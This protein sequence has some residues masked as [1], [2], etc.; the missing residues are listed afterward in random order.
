MGSTR[1]V[2]VLGAGTMGHG[3]AEVLAIHGIQVNVRDIERRFLDNAKQKIEWS[4]KKLQ[5][6]NQINENAERIMSRLSFELDMQ[7]AVRDC[8]LIIEAVPEDINVKK[9][10]FRQ[11]DVYTKSSAILATNTSSLPIGEISSAVKDPSRVVGIHFFNP[12]VMMKLV[13]VI[14]S[15]STSDKVVRDA[16]SLAKEISKVPILVQKDVP[17]FIVNRLL[18]RMMVTARLLVEKRM[19]TVEEV[20]SVLKYGAKLPMGA[21]ELADYIGLDVIT[22]V[23]KAMSQRGFHI[24]LGTLIEDKVREGKLGVK[25]GSG[26]YTY[27]KE[28]PKPVIPLELSSKINSALILAPSV[29]EAAWLLS[30][31]VASKDDIE[32]GVKLGLGFPEGL[33]HMADEWGI[34]VVISSL[35]SLYKA[36]GEAWLEPQQLLLSMV[37]EGR[38]GRKSKK[39]FFEY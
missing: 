35:K 13:E 33:L 9:D 28:Q 21:F 3:I 23:E 30:N 36:T 16:I 15:T 18:V 38:L 12:P 2:A 1:T 26:F 17:G 27:T 11:L 22:F 8:D 5:E 20:D 14:R 37:S 25:T 29:N 32:A 24:P 19:A 39:G 34:D 6:K 4:L 31:S 7:K 10:I